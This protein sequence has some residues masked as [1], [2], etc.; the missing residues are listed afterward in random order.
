M[1]NLRLTGSLSREQLEGLKKIELLRLDNNQLSGSVPNVWDH[2][3]S[4]TEIRLSQNSFT[5]PIPQK[6]D[7]PKKLGTY[8]LRC[9]SRFGHL[10][11]KYN[12]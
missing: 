7:H 6:L 11:R 9:A 4:L 12:T 5:G 1:D 10:K 2:T 8:S 3:P